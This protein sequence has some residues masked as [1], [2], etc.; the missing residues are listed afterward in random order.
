M[1]S[2]DLQNIEEQKLW[3]S[4]IQGD[5]NCLEKLYRRYFDALYNYGK[6]WLN[7]NTLTEDCIQDLFVELWEKR[8]VLTSDEPSSLSMAI[9]GLSASSAASLPRMM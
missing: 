9:V 5:D 8:E 1:E 3:V 2:N 7:N 6:K 4:F